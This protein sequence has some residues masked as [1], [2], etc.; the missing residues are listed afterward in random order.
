MV[1]ATYTKFNLYN[2]KKLDKIINVIKMN[3]LVALYCY[4]KTHWLLEES[5]RAIEPKV[6]Y[7]ELVQGCWPGFTGP[8]LCH[9]FEGEIAHRNYAL[10]LVK[11]GDYVIIMDDDDFLFGD[12]PSLRHMIKTHSPEVIWLKEYMASGNETIRPRIFKKQKGMSYRYNHQEMFIGERKL[13]GR[14]PPTHG[15][16]LI[17]PVSKFHLDTFKHPGNYETEM[18]YY[19]SHRQDKFP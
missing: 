5:V 7:V 3:Q 13:W 18:I 16:V 15:Q 14:T 11:E 4:L 1:I 12:W 8:N 6:N 9:K 17:S 2:P 19:L 10:S